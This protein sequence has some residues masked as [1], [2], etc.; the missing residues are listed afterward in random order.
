MVGEKTSV[1]GK[2][3]KGYKRGGLL[4]LRKQTRLATAAHACNPSYFRG[5]D[6]DDHN[7]R[8]AWANSSRENMSKMTRAEW[9][10]DWTQ[11]VECLRCQYAA[12]SSNPNSPKRKENRRVGGETRGSWVKG[13]C[14]GSKTLSQKQMKTKGLVACSMVEHLSSMK[15]WGPECNTQYHKKKKKKEEKERGRKEN[16]CQ[17][18]NFIQESEFIK[19]NK[20]KIVKPKT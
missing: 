5:W 9:S 15:P 17:D 20:M 10:R 12:L 8:P 18:K 7:L 1:E 13:Q 2:I 19:K 6:W 4:C 11:A 16:R 14:K 3:R